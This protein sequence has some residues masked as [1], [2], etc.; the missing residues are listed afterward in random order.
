[1]IIWIY[2]ALFAAQLVWLVRCCR[3]HGK[4]GI[5]LTLNIVS[6][7]ASCALMQYF[8]ALPGSGMMPGLTWFAEVFYSLGAAAVFAVL[9]LITFL[10]MLYHKKK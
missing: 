4:F 10:C 2:L 8:D 1:M 5:L 6:A 9:T 7:A 3:G